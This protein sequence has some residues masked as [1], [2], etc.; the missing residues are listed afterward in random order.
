MIESF[1]CFHGIKTK[2]DN[3]ENR[4]NTINKLM[5]V[6]KTRLQSER[7]KEKAVKGKNAARNYLHDDGDYGDL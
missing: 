7:K 6:L 2:N 3:D 1:T 5:L 4:L